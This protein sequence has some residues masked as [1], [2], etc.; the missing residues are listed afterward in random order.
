MLLSIVTPSYNRAS[1][2]ERCII[3]AREFCTNADILNDSELIVVDDASQDSTVELIQNKFAQEI[4]SDWLKIKKLTKNVGFLNAR[5]SGVSSAQGK[6]ILFLDSDDEL[7]PANAKEVMTK[8]KGSQNSFF[9]FR[10]KDADT[11]QIIGAEKSEGNIYYA[12]Y[13]NNGTPG[14]AIPLIQRELLLRYPYDSGMRG[15]AGLAYARMI[16]E[17][18]SLYWSNILARIYHQT[19]TGRLTQQRFARS[20]YFARGNKRYLQENWKALTL[21]NKLKYFIKYFIYSI[22]ALLRRE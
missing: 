3:S 12:D 17:I 18:G 6:W 22:I 4:A 16:K 15:S 7:I 21:K 2:I 5:N 9:Y 13:I 14:E 8:I 10:C 20:R 11:H 19:S 1:T